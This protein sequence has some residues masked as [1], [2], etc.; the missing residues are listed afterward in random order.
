MFSKSCVYAIKIMIY[1]ALQK[2]EAGTYVGVTEISEAID[3]PKAFTAKI[4]QQ[5]SQADLLES[6]R[7]PNGGFYLDKNKMVSLAKII[8]VIDGN[9][10]LDGCILGFKEC[11]DNRPCPVH[12]KL[13]SVRD[14]LKGALMTTDVDEMKRIIE[15]GKGYIKY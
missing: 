15:E 14:Y 2:D 8:R 3:S 13:R 4:L 5:L 7:G 9:Q 1:L 10:L 11:S 6:L 12:F